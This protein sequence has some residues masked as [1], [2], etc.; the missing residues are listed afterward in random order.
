MERPRPE[1]RASGILDPKDQ[2][3]AQGLFNYVLSH[4]GEVRDETNGLTIVTIIGRRKRN[5]SIEIYRLGSDVGE[6]TLR[7]NR[8]RKSW[9]DGGSKGLTGVF[10]EGSKV[11]PDQFH[12][13]TEQRDG[14]LR[15]VASHFLPPMPQS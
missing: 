2:E 7:F 12:P 10:M 3:I 9:Q 14:L 1:S 5:Q 6:V 13:S 8:G 4:G 11:E 15:T